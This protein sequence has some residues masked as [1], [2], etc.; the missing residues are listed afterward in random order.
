[1]Y[2]T[3]CLNDGNNESYTRANDL[4]RVAVGTAILAPLRN[5]MNI[6][7]I[8]HERS[9]LSR[10]WSGEGRLSW[11]GFLFSVEHRIKRKV[12]STSLVLQADVRTSPRR[13]AC[14]LTQT[15]QKWSLLLPGELVMSQLDSNELTVSRYLQL[16]EMHVLHEKRCIVY[17]LIGSSCGRHLCPKHLIVFHTIRRRESIE[18]RP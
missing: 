8:R 10:A 7:H 16:R 2:Q 18:R 14:Q 3:F 6:D 1:M 13:Y 17:F 15:I 9:W 5:I 4:M 11:K 12:Y